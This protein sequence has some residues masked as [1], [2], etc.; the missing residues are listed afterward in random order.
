MQWPARSC[1]E[2]PAPFAKTFAMAPSQTSRPPTNS[3]QSGLYKHPTSVI[4]AFTCGNT[5]L[6]IPP[7]QFHHCLPPPGAAPFTTQGTSSV[8]SPPIGRKIKNNA[9]GKVE[10]GIIAD[11]QQQPARTIC[12]VDPPTT[13]PAFSVLLDDDRPLVLLSPCLPT[14]V[15]P[16]ADLL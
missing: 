4:S 7:A 9:T 12:G 11:C 14:I 13:I 10:Q 2:P 8:P 5:H 1:F 6:P 16:P 3:W 15:Q